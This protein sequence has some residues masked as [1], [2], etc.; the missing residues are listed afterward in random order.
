MSGGASVGQHDFTRQL[1]EHL[2]YTVHVSKTNT[3]PG[4]PLVVAERGKSLA[5]GLPGNPLAHYVCLNLYVRAALDG[6]S[7]RPQESAFSQ[8]ILAAAIDSDANSRETFWPAHGRRQGRIASLTPL[9]WHSSGDITSLA[10]A[11]ALIRVGGGTKS[12]PPGS[13]VE[14]LWTG[15]SA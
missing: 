1:L 8:G 6:F 7:G 12:L 2:G 9:R 3:R 4:K 10:T 13:Y 14:F 15:H 11:N 5:L